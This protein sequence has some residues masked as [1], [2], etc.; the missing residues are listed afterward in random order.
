M[1]LKTFSGCDVGE[2]HAGWLVRNPML[3]AQVQAEK[4]VKLGL[5]QRGRLQAKYQYYSL[6]EA[7]K[8]KL[9]RIQPNSNP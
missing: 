4:L 8:A 7:G 9:R 3:P 6:T 5:L 2:E 1:N